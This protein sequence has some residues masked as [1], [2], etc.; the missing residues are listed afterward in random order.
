M[1]SLCFAYF[2]CFKAKFH[3]VNLDI[4]GILQNYVVLQVTFY[5]SARMYNL[6]CETLKKVADSELRISTAKN[7]HN[8][9]SD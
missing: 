5:A 2:V 7:G 1:K 9:L 6:Y 8:L 4:V 3:S